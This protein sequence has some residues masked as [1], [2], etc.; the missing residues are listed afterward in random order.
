[1]QRALT[2]FHRKPTHLCTWSSVFLFVVIL[3]CIIFHVVRTTWALAVWFGRIT[4]KHIPMRLL[5]SK[6]LQNTH[7]KHG[8]WKTTNLCSLLCQ[9]HLCEHLCGWSDDEVGS[10][11]KISIA[12]QDV[13]NEKKSLNTDTREKIKACRE[14]NVKGWEEILEVR[15]NQWGGVSSL[16]SNEHWGLLIMCDS[17]IIQP[18]R[19]NFST[20]ITF[21]KKSTDVEQKQKKLTKTGT[22][23]TI[24]VNANM[25]P[26]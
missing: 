16:V 7:Q 8:K 25:S 21:H 1:M 20:R 10:N 23:N 5:W 24:R 13:L 14:K 3:F 2:P 9:A 19:Y 4:D 15:L 17:D 6:H 18:R 26:L 11:K 22:C 12:K